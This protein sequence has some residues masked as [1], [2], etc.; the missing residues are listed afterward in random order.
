VETISPTGE[1]TRRA[2]DEL[3]RLVRLEDPAGGVTTYA[4]DGNGNLVEMID[5]RGG[6]T[7]MEYDAGNRLVRSID[8]AGGE[9]RF[10]YNGRGNLIRFTNA[11]GAVWRSTYDTFDRRRS[12][13]DPLGRTTTFTYDARN[14]LVGATDARGQTYTYTY[15]ALGRITQLAVPGN[16]VRRTYD[17]AGNVV[18]IEDDDSRLTFAYDGL[19]RPVTL[20]VADV[21]VQ[22]AVTLAQQLDALGQRTR[23]TDSLGGVTGYAYDARGQITDITTPAGESLALAY[24]AAGRMTQIDLPNG[25]TSSFGYDSGGRIA[26]LGYT[27]GGGTSLLAFGYLYDTVGNLIQI[28]EGTKVKSFSYDSLERLITGGTAGLPETYDYDAVG[29]RVSSLLSATY[30]HDAANRLLEDDRFLYTYDANG[31]LT[32]KIDKATAALTTYGYDGQDQLVSVT[33]PDGTAVSYRY[34]GIGRRIEKNVGGVVTRWIYDGRDILLELDGSNAVT[35]RYTHGPGVD[36]PLAV[37]RGGASYYYLADHQGSIRFLTDAAGDAVNSYEYDSFG[38]T[39]V[40]TETV[41]NPYRYTGRELDPETGLYYYRARYY[42]PETGRFI[43]Q[44]PL[45]FAG[46]ASNFYGYLENNPVLARDPSGSFS[47]WDALDVLS[48]LWS[49]KEF[50]DC[51]SLGNFANLA[52]DTI[53][54]LPIIP[55]IGTVRRAVDIADSASDAVRLGDRARD[56]VNAADNVHDAVNAADNASD[57]ARRAQDILGQSDD[58]VVIGRRPDTSIAEEWPGHNVLNDPNWSID[59]NDAWVAEAINQGRDVYVAS[60]TTADNLWDAANNRPT[61]FSREIQQFLDAGYTRQGDYLI[62]P[63]R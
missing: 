49:A 15:D 45:R 37:E 28:A 42:D 10:A 23:L 27:D 13:T 38:R 26:S 44:D 31:N 52:L 25:I 5:G 16:L 35:A 41:A 17:A 24:D 30:R 59:L 47:F 33:L 62:P 39:L 3:N 1:V 36:R 57:V 6:R 48:F 56:A 2:F 18:S 58:V 34:D 12:V 19:N 14:L 50:I 11:A 7:V 53:G 9:Q 43:S 46:G 32:S 29:N 4:Y 8:P 22:P 55:G 21:G 63:G 51:P 20:G 40:E 61:V 60:P 54:L